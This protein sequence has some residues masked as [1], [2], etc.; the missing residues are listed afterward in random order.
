M[1]FKSHKLKK[2]KNNYK[3]YQDLD[4]F[5]KS[6]LNLPRSKSFASIFGEDVDQ[7]MFYLCHYLIFINS[8][9]FGTLAIS[10]CQ[11]ISS[12]LV[13]LSKLLCGLEP[14]MFNIDFLMWEE[15][16]FGIII[17]YQQQRLGFTSQYNKLMYLI[18]DMLVIIISFYTIT[19][20]KEKISSQLM[21]FYASLNS[22]VIICRHI[23]HKYPAK[24]EYD[25]MNGLP[26]LILT[27]T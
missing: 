20:N 9:Y 12:K 18:I 7:T 15:I 14:F 4:L 11:V 17:W 21:M 19:I 26:F 13:L 6:L 25:L 16:V 22:I 24:F 27:I 10:D 2:I 1:P 5:I 23:Y 8:F 3:D